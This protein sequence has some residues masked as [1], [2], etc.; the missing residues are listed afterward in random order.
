MS[1]TFFLQAET[2]QF[3]PTTKFSHF[4]GINLC[5]KNELCIKNNLISSKF[6]FLCGCLLK[7]CSKMIS[8]AYKKDKCNFKMCLFINNKAFREYFQADN[9]KHSRKALLLINM[10]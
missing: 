3:S 10:F 7:N 6:Q 4:G 5:G 1:C 8:T 2:L 9:V